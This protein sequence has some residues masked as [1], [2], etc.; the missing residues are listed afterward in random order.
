MAWVRISDDFAEHPKLRDLSAPAVAM[1]AAGIAYANRN[2]TDGVIPRRVTAGLINLDGLY[3]PTANRSYRPI[4]PGDL[5]A[6]LI[7]HELWH[8]CD[9]NC[10]SGCA[11]IS[12]TE[13]IIHDYLEYQPS[14]DKVLINREKTRARVSRH[15]SRIGTDGNGVTSG[16]TNGGVTRAPKS[17]PQELPRPI[18]SSPYSV[19]RADTTD[20]VPSS[21]FLEGMAARA[22]I[23]D[24][25]AIVQLI[26]DKTG[27]HIT[28]DRA[29]GV[30]KWILDKSTQHI[31]VPQRYVMAAI[32]KSPAEIEQH[33][34]G[35]AVLA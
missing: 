30:G 23:T 35:E 3:E 13:Y 17:Q 19:G 20:S 25:P 21:K 4:T 18:E 8:D 32:A 10:D 28:G 24:V 1:W 33:L 27:I 2:L 15:R 34:T 14:R 16:D 5:V 11:P 6:Q 12:E 29:I 31:A 7:A 9:H 22:G 26:A